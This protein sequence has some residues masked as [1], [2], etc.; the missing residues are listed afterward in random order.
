MAW[1]K[2]AQRLLSS[3]STTLLCITCLILLSF[4]IQAEQHD[5][6]P[7]DA[8]DDADSTSW[9]HCNCPAS[10]PEYV[11]DSSSSD[12]AKIA[13]LISVHNRRTIADGAY[14]VKA[15]METSRPGD[16]AIILIHVDKRVGIASKKE[17]ESISDKEEDKNKY[18]YFHSPLK[19]YVDACLANPVCA[20]SD[21][22]HDGNNT[23]T[24]LEVH[25]HYAPEWSK[26]SM[27]DPTIWAMD[28]LIH[29]PR[30]HNTQHNNTWDVFINLSGDT[31]PVVPAHRISQLFSSQG[32]LANTNFVTSSSC[33]TGLLPTSIYHFPKHWMKRAHYFQHEIPKQFTYLDLLLGEWK[34]DVD[35]AI[36]FGSQWMALTHEF[37]EY[38]VR[39][40]DH[41]NG[42]GNV[43]ME[44]FLRTEVLM[45]DETFF[46]TL[47]MNSPAFRDT[48][49]K[50]NADGALEKF[51]TLR[52]LRYERMDE[53]N[54]NPWGKYHSNNPLYDIPPK[55]GE[56]TDGEGA[57]KPWGPYFLGVYDLG[58]I[59][60]SGALFVRKVSRTVDENLVRMLPVERRDGEER[61]EWELLPD[62][63]WPN[64]GV[65]VHD[66]FVWRALKHK[67]KH[68]EEMSEVEEEE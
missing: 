47:L 32:P 15:L 68:N 27:N 46:A 24:L 62:I 3:R 17:N 9:S 21:K 40:M 41:P 6:I 34:Q 66:P 63:R 52:H 2:E 45:T 1:L 38:V 57:A 65:K 48:I 31:L 51:P 7:H 11:H 25:S 59:R 67:S 5:E 20:S 26:W 37:V 53:N 49:P 29:H 61:T 44:T 36:Y 55:F 13:Y 12:P 23:A 4:S 16:T 30:F 22:R 33:I 35:V 8:W 43:L 28:Y 18:L 14:L 64:L 42:F 39:S 50:L 54:P 58:A 10:R 56:A 60:D 19:R